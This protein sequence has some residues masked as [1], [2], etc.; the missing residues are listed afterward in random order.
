MILFAHEKLFEDKR[1]TDFILEHYTGIVVF[2]QDKS[3]KFYQ[4]NRGRLPHSLHCIST[5]ETGFYDKYPELKKY[6]GE[7][8]TN[9]DNYQRD[10]LGYETCNVEKN[11]KRFGNNIL[12][13]EAGLKLIEHYRPF[14][15]E[16]TISS[17][18]NIL[19]E[20]YSI[21][22]FDVRIKNINGLRLYGCK[23]QI[24]SW[25]K[26]KNFGAYF[27]SVWIGLEENQND[28][29][30][31]V[32]WAIDHHKQINVY[33][34]NASLTVEKFLMLGEKLLKVCKGL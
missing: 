10:K 16:V 34:G 21:F 27:S 19:L 5:G 8:L 30:K 22:G 7:P 2:N 31:P 24:S 29:E 11:L 6:V 15:C 25:E 33:G 26:L 9:Y 32:L 23:N 12:V 1:A 4:E 28:Y 18:K 3:E 20:V 13:D 14:D 17:Y